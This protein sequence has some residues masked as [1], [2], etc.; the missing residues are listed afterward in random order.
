MAER[1]YEVGYGKPPAEHRFKAG[2]SGNPKGRPKG[3]RG[4]RH[5][6]EQALSAKVALT[7]EGQRKLVSVGEALMKRLVQRALVDGELRAIERLLN[8]A[9]QFEGPENGVGEQPLGHDDRAVLDSFRR[10]VRED[11]A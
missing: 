10:R 5:L 8:L 11:K 6:V 7:E 1:G 9:Q 2:K 4:F 3:A